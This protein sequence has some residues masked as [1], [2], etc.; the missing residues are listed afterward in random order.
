MIQRPHRLVL[1]AAISLTTPGYAGFDKAALDARFNSK[2]TDHG[3]IFT[4]L[5]DGKILYEKNS[6]QLMSPASV[7]KIITS[8][9]ALSYFGPAFSF[10]TPL[11]HTG[12][13][14]N[15]RLTGDLLIQG[16]GDPFLVSEILW[17]TAIDLRH[18]GIKSIDGDIVIDTSLYDDEDRDQS[19]A[20]GASHST[21]AYDAPVSA[22]AVN[23]NTVAVAVAPTSKGSSA[24]LSTTPFP[25][26]SVKLSGRVMTTSGSSDAVSASRTTLK[27][28]AI[29]LSASGSIGEEAAIK[30][31]YRS[32]AS[33]VVS[34]GDYFRGFLEDAGIKV[35]GKV[36]TGSIPKSA[37]LMYEIQGY[38]MRKITAGLN[39]FSN[40]FI[41]DM[42]T[43]RLGAA[44]PPK[45][46]VDAPGSG[47]LING[48]QVLTKFLRD[49][50][51]IKSGFTMLNGSGLSTENRL[52]PRQI[53]TVLQWMERQGELFPD[54]LGSLP[55][56]G[57]DGTLKKRI[58]KAD[59]LAGM[60]RAKSGTLTEPIVVAG[61]AGYFRHPTEGWVSFVMLA[62]GREGKGQPGL[63]D[64]RNLQDET[65]KSIFDVG[66]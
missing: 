33:P 24:I 21:H 66:K 12:H 64:V 26:H 36:R 52:S 55:A 53:V 41:A 10:K 23:F 11:Y 44:F 27:G 2:T 14:A 46:E 49:D 8:A 43:K 61:M 7:T 35:K 45:G 47:T 1:V 3:V 40:N 20:E 63:L 30:K 22:F 42:L 65:L 56:N 15:G 62:N 51:G 60:I 13:L 34:A 16:N 17:Q 57:W 18:L 37:G 6:D 58:K 48:I 50:V 31:I 59:A 38:D 54:F 39:T 32:V 29:S 25:M 4:R 5:S 28:G 9:A 19:R